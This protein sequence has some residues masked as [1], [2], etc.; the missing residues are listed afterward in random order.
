[1]L[2][3]GKMYTIISTVDSVSSHLSALT[4]SADVKF[5]C[6]ILN[7]VKRA[8]I[9]FRTPLLFNPL[10]LYKTVLTWAPQESMLFETYQISSNPKVAIG[11][12]RNWGPLTFEG[13]T[14]GVLTVKFYL[15]GKRIA[16]GAK[17]NTI[18]LW[19]AS[20]GEC[21][22]VLEGHTDRVNTIAISKDSRWLVS[23]SSD[24]FVKVFDL[25]TGDCVVTLAGHTAYVTSVQISADGSRVYSA[26]L[27]G[28]IKVWD[29]NAQ[30]CLATFVAESVVYWISVSHDDEILAAA[31]KDKSIKIFN[32][33]TNTLSTILKGHEHGVRCVEIS[34][35]KRFLV[36]ASTD[37][38]LKSWS[39]ESGKCT[40]TIEAHD[41]RLLYC[42]MNKDNSLI[43]STST[44]KTCKVW[45]LKTGQLITVLEG[46]ANWV[47]AGDWSPTNDIVT[48]GNDTTLKVWGQRDTQ[49]DQDKSHTF[50]VTE[51]SASQDNKYLASASKDKTIRVWDVTQGRCVSVKS[52][53]KDWV[54]TIAI[55]RDSQIIASGG[56]DQTIKVWSSL[57]HQPACLRTLTGHSDYI[58]SVA[59]SSDNKRIVSGSNDS[60]VKLWSIETGICLKT[61][62]AHSGLVK[63]VAFSPDDKYVLSAGRD[64]VVRAWSLET[65]ECVFQVSG[66]SKWCKEVGMCGTSD[67]LFVY[68]RFHH[69]DLWKRVDEPDTF[70]VWSFKTKKR[71]DRPLYDVD[72][73]DRYGLAV[74]EG[75]LFNKG[76]R[77][78]WLP[79]SV[80]GPTGMWMAQDNVLRLVK[81]NNIFCVIV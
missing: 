72:G 66:D 26:S 77:V 16:S 79:D 50:D 68:A 20:T 75:W 3:M 8:C 49:P 9:N 62:H 18:R 63:S 67:N 48:A 15:Y 70:T 27:D 55:S 30:Q 59:I 31:L 80:R 57:P 21:V 7:D 42:S 32:L 73:T 65:G 60:T 61:F 33:S 69:G 53:H 56:K 23:G 51:V 74:R 36:S 6:Q 54:N 24:T 43:L 76:H 40:Q 58:K 19:N 38:T 5:I 37:C 14:I 25:W 1:M 10:H 13:H 44:D 39:L 41:F 52:G 29:V 35:D 64:S 71:V 2:L 17:D 4:D 81:G 45:D 47:L 22:Q 34:S 78:C 46:H 12:L 11:A 28:I